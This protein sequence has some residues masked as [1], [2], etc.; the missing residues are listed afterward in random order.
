MSALFLPD[1]HGRLGDYALI[2]TPISSPKGPHHFNRVVFSAA[3]VVAD[4]FAAREP[5]IGP[6]IDWEG[7]LAYRRHLLDLGLGIAEAM[8]TAQ[9]GG[10]LDWPGALELIGQSLRAAA[11]SERDRIFSG[12][13]TDQLAPA[14]ARSIDDVIRAY[15]EQIEAIQKL[16]GRIILMASR[17]LA[18]VATSAKDYETVYSKV[19]A[20]CDKPVILH[21]LGDMFDPAL[22]GYWGAKNF[23]AA[24][25]TAL[26]V[27]NDNTSKVDGI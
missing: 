7:T 27:I 10:G 13:G 26:E 11:P 23:E 6:A 8:D 17:A 19:L 3:H 5:G 9:R 2:G 16:D 15:H 21:W 1:D 12:A 14:D 22:A 25:E 18:K 4:P 24:L 20:A